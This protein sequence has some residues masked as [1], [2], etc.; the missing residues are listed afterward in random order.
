MSDTETTSAADEFQA[1]REDAEG[2]LQNGLTE[3]GYPP[4][5]GPEGADTVDKALFLLRGLQSERD[6]L[7]TKLETAEKATKRA[8]AKVTAGDA[9]AKPRKLTTAASELDRDALKDAIA[10]AEKVEVAF[11]DGKAEI[12]GLAPLSVEGDS[13]KDHTR[14]LMLRDP[15]ELP[16]SAAPTSVSVKGYAL[17]LDG[18]QAAYTERSDPLTIAPGQ[19]VG[20][21]DDIYF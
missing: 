10:S 2:R 18:K 5:A 20:L 19:R 6:E 12:A 7:A 16:P 17:L 14:G 9:P 15:V 3:L 8:K 13:W 4:E 11:S 1:A 21:T